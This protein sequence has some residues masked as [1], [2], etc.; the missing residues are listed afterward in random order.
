M[1]WLWPRKL[2]SDDRIWV[3]IVRLAHW[4][5]VGFAVFGLVVSFFGMIVGGNREPVSYVAVAS[6]WIALAMLGRGLLYVLVRE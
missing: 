6:V 1:N 3:R 2:N 4:F 5:I